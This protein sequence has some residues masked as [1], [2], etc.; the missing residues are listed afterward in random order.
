[1]RHIGGW[2]CENGRQDRDTEERVAKGIQA[3]RIVAKAWSI[4]TKR[5]RG[6]T[7]RMQ[8]HV[9][10]KIMKAIV[11][12]TLTVFCKS[13]A[14]NRMQISKM[15]KVANYAVRRAMGMDQFRMMEH[16]IKDIDLCAAARWETIGSEVRRSTLQWL[17]HAARMSI[18]RRP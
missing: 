7:G 3:A 1:M 12:P 8:T 14:W 17:G 10:L 2:I 6:T 11:R 13:R 5:G 16:N 9:K 18:D 15:Q 4:G